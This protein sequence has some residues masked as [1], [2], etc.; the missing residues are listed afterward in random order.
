MSVDIQTSKEP[1]N[2]VSHSVRVGSAVLQYGVG[3]MVDFPDQTLMTAAPEYWKTGIIP[4]CDER[5]ENALD[6]VDLLG[7]PGGAEGISYVRFPEWY[8][9][10]KCRSFKPISSWVKE[11]KQ[12]AK[13]SMIEKDPYM[14]RH[15]QCPKCR[16]DLVVSRI[17]TACEKGHID[18]FP[19][20]EWVHARNGGG[21]APK[22]ICVSPDLT[23]K[24]GATSAEGLESLE[25]RCKTCGA[26]ATLKDAFTPEIFAR[27]DRETYGEYGFHC[28]GRHPWKHKT[29]GCGEY[30]KVMQRGS[31]SVYFPVIESSLVIPPYSSMLTTKIENSKEFE[32][33]KKQLSK[34]LGNPYLSEENKVQQKQYYIESYSED[35][36]LEISVPVSAVKKVLER[37]WLTNSEK[38]STTSLSYRA[39][40]YEALSGEMKLSSGADAD[41]IR[42]A[43]DISEY[44][45]PFVKQISLIHKIREVRALTGFT[46]V[47]PAGSAEIGGNSSNIVSVKEPETKWYPA[48][49]VRGEGIFIELD[50]DM[51]DKWRSSNP[52]LKERID[53]LN[54]NYKKSYFGQLNPKEISAK[55]LLLHTLAH[56]LIKQMSFECGYSIASLRERIYCSEA[57]E[58]KKMTGILVYTA[59][60]DSEGTLGGLVRQGRKDVFPHLFEKALRTALTCSNDPVCSLS[61]GQGR[62]SLNLAACYSCTLIPETSCEAYNAFLDRGV[63]VGTLKNKYLG[64]FSP[65]LFGMDEEYDLR[66]KK[67]SDVPSNI[68]AIGTPAVSV[69][70]GIDMTETPYNEIFEDQ[71]DWATSD[72]DEQAYTEML[73]LTDKFQFKE[74]PLQD[75]TFTLTGSKKVYQC[76]LLWKKSE[77]MFFS[78]EHTEDYVSAKE[79]NWKCFCTSDE[80]CRVTDLISALK[81]I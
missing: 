23:I 3:A 22:K 15:M 11:Y 59:S 37:K 14:V 45:L 80:E 7:M 35:I 44:K 4:I 21:K 73:S 31:S 2:A 68:S 53:L 65:Y 64:F 76:D 19:W 34:A 75:S 71:K 20:V 72:C 25:I 13:S 49:Q 63:V 47:N 79:S 56:L 32:D 60:G 46:R 12:T 70:D 42:E 55:F 48:Y 57:S 28:K 69:I 17:V 62:D 78:S 51:I 40:E 26:M 9:C 18:D 36:A 58:G 43:T 10:P 33:C 1:L 27:I 67:R 66:R 77:V 8:F 24:T 52:D 50:S 41:F 61:K 39:E 81:E 54:E 6:N 29:E 38:K 5:L 30:P 16:V 74:K